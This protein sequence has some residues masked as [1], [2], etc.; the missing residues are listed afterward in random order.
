M[1][2]WEKRSLSGTPLFAA[3]NSGKGFFSFYKDVFDRRGLER[4]YLIKGGPGTGKSYLLRSVAEYAHAKG[5]AVEYYRCSSDP[6]SLDGIVIDERIAVLDA[7][8]PHSVEPELPGARDEIVNLGAFWDADALAVHAE[9]IAALTEKKSECY[10]RAYRFLAACDHLYADNRALILPHVRHA[11]LQ[12]AVARRLECIPRG[13]GYSLLPG[14]CDAIG[15]KGRVHLDSYEQWAKKLYVIEDHHD[16]GALFLRALLTRGMEKECAMRVSY[17]PI[18]V[19][20][21]DA[22]YFCDTG[23]CFVIANGELPEGKSMTRINMKRFVDAEGVRE[24]RSK[25]RMNGRMYEALLGSAEEALGEA[26]KHHFDLERIYAAGMDFDAENR[27]VR[28]FCEKI[29]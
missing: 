13:R 4:R 2:Q 21:P 23:D 3:A 28:S 10:R 18:H 16:T 22:V 17:H 8:A 14:L 20:E 9:E 25:L 27:F 24:V 29:L 5:K 15:M 12:G 7:T 6:D 11:K 19:G 26:G 1:G